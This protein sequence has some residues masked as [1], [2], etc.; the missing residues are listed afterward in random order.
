MK[1]KIFF[2]VIY[3]LF[4]SAA[5]S[6]ETAES[7]I[8]IS[9]ENLIS[10]IK[11]IKEKRDTV[12]FENEKNINRFSNSDLKGTNFEFPESSS[13]QQSQLNAI[14][15]KLQTLEYDIKLLNAS[16]NSNQKKTSGK[17]SLTVVTTPRNATTTY[18]TIAEGKNKTNTLHSEE[19]AELEKKIITLKKEAYEQLL[20][21]EK[22]ENLNRSKNDYDEIIRLLNSKNTSKDTLIIEK[23]EIS[24]YPELMKKFDSFHSEVHF[25]NNSK[26]IKESQTKQLDEIVSILKSTDKIDVYLKG[27][28]SNKGNPIYNQNLSTQRTENVKKYLVKNGI[29]PS[30]ILTQY[31][32]IDYAANKEEYAR[33]VELSFIIR[34]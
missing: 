3:F 22:Q 18:S 29:H 25:D 21:R 5:Q 24:D 12:I 7:V 16:L 31:H 30:R 8:I 11:K 28:A 9:E 34:K 23:R 19:V 32:G 26:A 10:L 2:I 13:K 27:F 20:T 15:A 6:Q 17:G 33:R 14:Y 4:S 1:T